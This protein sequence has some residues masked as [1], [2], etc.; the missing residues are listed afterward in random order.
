MGS[1]YEVRIAVHGLIP[2]TEDERGIKDT[3]VFQRLR[4]VKQLA[5]TDLVYPSA[6][7]TRF[8][9]SL[10][11]MHVAGKIAQRLDLPDDE[12]RIVRLAAM[13]HDIGH[14]PFSHVSEDVIDKLVG[15]EK[16]HEFYGAAVVLYH[17]DFAGLLSQEDRVAISRLIAPVQSTDPIFPIHIEYLK[18][19]TLLKDIV[20]GPAD[21][22]KM[23]Y[24]LRD[25]HHCGVKYG[26]FDLDKVV[27]A[28]VPIRTLGEMQ[29]GFEEDAV[30]ALEQMILARHHM[31][32][33]VYGHT[34]R[35]ITDAMLSRSMAL[36]FDAEALSSKDFDW[37]SGKKN[38]ADFLNRYLAWDDQ[39]LLQALV[40][41][42]NAAGDLASRLLQRRLLK[43]AFRM[44]LK[45]M[46]ARHNFAPDVLSLFLSRRRFTKN[47]VDGIEKAISEMIAVEKHLVFVTLDS[48]ENPT[49][50]PPAYRM[51][52]EVLPKDIMLQREDGSNLPFLSASEVF[53]TGM[54][55]QRNYLTVYCPMDGLT[56]AKRDERKA[57]IEASLIEGLKGFYDEFT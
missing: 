29:L 56:D 7:H 36:G 16:T 54:E 34:T 4:R 44:E 33:Q 48:V 18:R 39:R 41:A 3:S 51:E 24:L 2:V 45:E 26:T 6:N 49:Y 27:A 55:E 13:L 20:S 42:P 57:A 10:G 53:A 38:P 15:L 50:K 37:G 35:A 31:H 12:K 25:S 47:A 9:H 5:L 1:E 17:Q 32:R 28:A 30:W 43:E 23:D 19:R 52:V 46:V 14:G 8:E 11:A 40:D 22:D 21:A